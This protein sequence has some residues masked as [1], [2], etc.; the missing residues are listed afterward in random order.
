MGSSNL[1]RYRVLVG[2]DEKV[3]EMDIGDGCTVI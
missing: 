3:T 1:N 2:E